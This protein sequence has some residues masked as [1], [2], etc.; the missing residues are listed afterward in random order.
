MQMT[1]GMFYMGMQA[2]LK[3]VGGL[4]RHDVMTCL[5]T[6]LLYLISNSPFRSLLTSRLDSHRKRHGVRHVEVNVAPSEA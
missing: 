4:S 5:A 1:A 3:V 6:S 2:C